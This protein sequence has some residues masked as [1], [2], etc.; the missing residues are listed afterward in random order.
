MK[1]GNFKLYIFY[2]VCAFLVFGSA[3]VYAQPSSST[4]VNKDDLGFR[5]VDINEII[6]TTYLRDSTYIYFIEDEDTDEWV[7]QEKAIYDYNNQGRVLLKNVLRLSETGWCNK[8]QVRSTYISDFLSSTVEYDWANENSSWIPAGKSDF[9]YNYVGL[10]DEISNFTA[11]NSSWLATSK[12]SYTY[13]T[14]YNI[15]EEASFDWNPDLNSWTPISRFLFSYNSNEDVKKE[16]FQTWNDSLNLWVNNTSKIFDYNDSQNLVSTIRRNWDSVEASWLNTGIV[17]NEYNDK[18]QI[19]ASKQETIGQNEEVT[20]TQFEEANYDSDGN[21][22]Q[23]VK[24]QWDAATESWDIYQKHVHFWAEYNH[25]NLDKNQNE[26]DCFFANPYTIGL[27]L[28]CESLKAD[29]LYTVSVYDL[30]GRFFYSGQFLG[31]SSF[32]IKDY[33]EPGFYIFQITGGLDTHS[34]KVF[35]KN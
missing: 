1:T 7:L 15:S 4:Y 30:N 14:N 11:L 12:T 6:S 35:I 3:S 27:P 8:Q 10:I 21:V 31:N 23:I 17:V 5:R 28:Y 33:L 29:V 9:T 18:G 24:S 20:P 2:A 32:R 22:G 13:N 26:I 19:K 34:E 25:G 16:V